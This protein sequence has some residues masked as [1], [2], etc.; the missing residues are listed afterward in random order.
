MKDIENNKVLHQTVTETIS[1]LSKL[2]FKRQQPHQDLE[3]VKKKVEQV[4]E[5]DKSFTAREEQEAG[6]EGH[7]PD[8]SH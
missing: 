3:Q 7:L 8:N 5:L 2:E 4:K 1:K 6:Q